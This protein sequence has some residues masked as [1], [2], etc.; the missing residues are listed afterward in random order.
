MRLCLGEQERLPV[1]HCELTTLA[2]LDRC[3]E[4]ELVTNDRRE[5]RGAALVA[6]RSAI[7]NQHRHAA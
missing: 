5:T 1:P 4:A 6:S 2:R 3:R 7:A